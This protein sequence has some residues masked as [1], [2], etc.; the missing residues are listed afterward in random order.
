MR[1]RKLLDEYILSI[2]VMESSV[3]MTSVEMEIL[4]SSTIVKIMVRKRNRKYA[5]TQLIVEDEI[6]FPADC[7]NSYVQVRKV[8][9]LVYQ[10]SIMILFVIYTGRAS[11]IL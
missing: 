10:S 7:P 4:N 9:T 6:H 5:L 11:F 8:T 3:T 2:A 1:E